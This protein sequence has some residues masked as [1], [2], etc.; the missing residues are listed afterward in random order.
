[1]P[2]SELVRRQAEEEGLHQVFLDAGFDWRSP[3][4][5]M[6]LGANG[7]TVGEG[8]RVVST[9]NR[10]F[11]NRQGPGSRTHIASPVLAA[12]SALA[13]F[14]TDPRDFMGEKE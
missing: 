2:G 13:G 8:V 5:S 3:G 7:D 1:V 9:A 12:A 14:I 4:C 6:C 10:S 11:A